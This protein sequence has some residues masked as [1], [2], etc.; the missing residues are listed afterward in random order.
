M[1]VIFSLGFSAHLVWDIQCDGLRGFP[2]SVDLLGLRLGLSAESMQC[3]CM[4]EYLL[5]FVLL[6]SSLLTSQARAL[7]CALSSLEAL[8]F[9]I[10]PAKIVPGSS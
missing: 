5:I 8:A 4:W 2:K 6:F 3:V 10:L 9:S 1:I 7:Q